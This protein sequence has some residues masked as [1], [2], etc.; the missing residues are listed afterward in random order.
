MGYNNTR[1]SGTAYGRRKTSFSY[2]RQKSRGPA[3]E[4]INPTRFISKAKTVEPV[5]YEP[6]HTFADFQVDE[7]IHANLDAKGFVSPTPI[8]DQT[9]PAG[10]EGRD[11]VGIADTGTGKT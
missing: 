8:Q 9:I 5:I 7:L 11:I 10:L 3:K 1:T 2:P 4:Y 6:K